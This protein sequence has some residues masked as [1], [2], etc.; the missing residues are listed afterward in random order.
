VWFSAFNAYCVHAL[1]HRIWLM[2][3]QESSTARLTL[4]DIVLVAV[5]TDRR[6]Q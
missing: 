5:T 3:K 6:R 2:G 1:T 4:G